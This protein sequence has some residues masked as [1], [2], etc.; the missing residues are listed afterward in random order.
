MADDIMLAVLEAQRDNMARIVTGLELPGTD[1]YGN[2]VAL[3]GPAP[4]LVRLYDTPLRLIEG[5]ALAN[6][7]RLITLNPLL[8]QTAGRVVQRDDRTINYMMQVMV[9]LLPSEEAVDRVQVLSGDNSNIRTTNPLATKAHNLLHD[10]RLAFFDNLFL[11]TIACPSGLVSDQSYSISWEP[12]VDYPYSMF[13]FEVTAE[14]SG[15]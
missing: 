9:R 6:W 4:D 7:E 14:V 8:D 1:G 12:G 2:N 11:T 5:A 13:T 3:N 15:V 10:M